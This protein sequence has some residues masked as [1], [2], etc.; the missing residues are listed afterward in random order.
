[1]WSTEHVWQVSVVNVN[2]APYLDSPPEQYFV[3][4]SLAPGAIAYTSK[5]APLCWSDYD[6]GQTLTVTSTSAYFVAVVVR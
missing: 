3:N 5:G 1:M 4:E 2:K 6:V